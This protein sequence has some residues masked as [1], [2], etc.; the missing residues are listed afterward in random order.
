MKKDNFISVGI[1]LTTDTKIS[2]IEELQKKLS[3]NYNYFEI[4][5]LNCE[6]DSSSYDTLLKLLSNIRVLELLSSVDIEVAH[7][8]LIENSIG[9]YCAIID[10]EHDGIDDLFNMLEYAETHDVVIGKREKKIQSVFEAITSKIFYKTISLFTGIKIDS[11]YSDFFVI[12]RKVI[13]FITKNEDK[14]KFLKLL[15]FSNGFTKYENVYMPLGKKST[16]RTFFENIN[17]TIDILVNN[18]QRLIRMATI[19]SLGSSIFNFFYIFYVFGVYLF[20]VNIAQGWTSS[21]IYSSVVYFVLFL[22]LAVIGEYIRIIL[23]NQKD[24]PLYE[25]IDEKSSVALFSDKKNIDKE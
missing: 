3:E 24:T 18:S 5:L 7:T 2:K 4:I 8:T 11:M 19:L 13:N 21:N 23:Q 9:D 12:N 10:L 14:V 15:Q 22:V 20:K 16:N 1:V 17:F 6:F 25:I